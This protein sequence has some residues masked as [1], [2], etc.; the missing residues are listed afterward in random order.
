GVG[1]AGIDIN[2]DPV[3]SA[4]GF[5]GANVTVAVVDSGLEIAHEDLSANVVPG[6]SWNFINGT[7]NPT[8]TATDGDHGTEVSGLIAMVRNSVGGVGVAPGAKLKGFNFLSSVQTEQNFLNSLG[9]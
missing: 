2:V 6:G 5:T 1:V 8:S 3:F 7:T 9:A 4:F